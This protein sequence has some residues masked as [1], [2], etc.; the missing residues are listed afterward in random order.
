MKAVVIFRSPSE[1][2]RD[3]S[4][5]LSMASTLRSTAV[6]PGHGLT[7]VGQGSDGNSLRSL[8]LNQVLGEAREVEAA[9]DAHVRAVH[10]GSTAC[11]G[12]QECGTIM[13][14]AGKPFKVHSDSPVASDNA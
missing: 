9:A 11:I 8:L 10:G 4:L 12:K 13:A 7:H 2:E 5:A 3:L 14:D 1:A 6:A